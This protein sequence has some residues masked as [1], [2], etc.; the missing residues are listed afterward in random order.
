MIP[1]SQHLS[2]SNEKQTEPLVGVPDQAQLQDR[3]EIIL[4]VNTLHG[5]HVRPAARFVQTAAAF[6]SRIRVQKL[7]SSKGPVSATSLNGRATLDVEHGDRILVSASGPD[8]Q[9]ALKALTALV[10]Q[11]F[12]TLAEEMTPAPEAAAGQG[13]QGVAAIAVSEGIALGPIF[14]YQAP[15]PKVP[16]HRAANPDREWKDLLRARDHTCRAIQR[17]LNTAL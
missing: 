12:K 15:S 11:E 7:G 5:L 4:P 3:Q 14:H 13:G 1:K 2:G 10:D 9:N 6:N 8:A 17:R 16:R